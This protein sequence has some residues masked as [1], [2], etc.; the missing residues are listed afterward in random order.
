MG[1]NRPP[2]R[3]NSS[4]APDLGNNSGPTQHE[5]FGEL[6]FDEIQR[7]KRTECP[8]NS[9]EIHI[10]TGAGSNFGSVSRGNRTSIELFSGSFGDWTK[11]LIALAQA[12]AT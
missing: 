5:V 10:K 9:G 1:R 6:G 11:W 8:L 3:E 2:R 4:I 7:G 12:L